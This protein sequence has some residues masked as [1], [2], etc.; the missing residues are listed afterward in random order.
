MV[1]EPELEGS[2][3]FTLDYLKTRNVKCVTDDKIMTSCL[4]VSVYGSTVHKL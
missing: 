2:E 4:C 3:V 1:E